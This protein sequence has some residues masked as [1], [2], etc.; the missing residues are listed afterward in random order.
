MRFACALAVVVV[1][2]AC[3]G[4]AANTGSAAPAPSPPPSASA[5]PPAPSSAPAPAPAAASASPAPTAP[6]ASPELAE[7]SEHRERH[8]GGVQM[9]VLMSLK[10]LDLSADQR[11]S[12][13]K[14]RSDLVVKMQPARDAGQALS[15]TLADGVAAG[16]VDR[17]KVNV[18]IDKLVAQ[19]QALH[20]A[21]ASA[22]DDLH[23]ALNK[24][25]RAKL[26][27]AMKSHWDKWKEAHGRDEAD[28]KE[29][30]AGHLATL[31]RQLGLTKE[32]A[33]KIK[34]SFHGA[35]KKAPQEH[36]HKEVQEHLEALATA[37]KADKFEAKTLKGGKAANGHLARWGATRMA[38]FLEAAAPVLTAEQRTKLAQMIRD[39]STKV[40]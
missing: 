20:E 15:T 36:V 21:A 18:A 22:L 2:P 39:R 19:V 17:A 34:A 7:G 28:D 27:D 23:A 5:A 12:I 31:V 4:A 13:E 16:A 3:G 9:L 35:M 24:E 8:H 6:P 10:D 14:I 1:L 29:H 38:R 37:F 33:E 26:V 25:Q 40:D 11:A 32:E 30:H